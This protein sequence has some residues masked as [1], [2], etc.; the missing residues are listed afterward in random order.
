MPRK[1]DALTE[2]TIQEE[3]KIDMLER[4][5]SAVLNYLSDDEIE[6]IDIEYLLTNTKDLREWWDQYREKNKKQIEDEIKKSLS[7]LSLE[8]LEQIREQIK[9]KNG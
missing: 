6:E 7:K 8:D 5:L 9:K 3:N 1:N 2:E 4:M